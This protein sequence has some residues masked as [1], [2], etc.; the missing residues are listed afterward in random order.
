MIR[1]FGGLF[2]SVKIGRIV[3]SQ[4]HRDAMHRLLTELSSVV[5]IDEHSDEFGRRL[6][7]GVL[8]MFRG[9]WSVDVFF[10]WGGYTKLLMW[11][12]MVFESQG[13]ADDDV[14]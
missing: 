6:T 9:D 1:Y 2:R 8:L 3:Y 13:V 11:N 4:Q 5:D 12:S 14:H 7:H 10:H